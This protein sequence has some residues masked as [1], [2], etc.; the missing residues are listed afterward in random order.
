MDPEA[1]GEGGEDEFYENMFNQAYGDEEG[2]FDDEGE[3]AGDGDEDDES[4]GDEDEGPSK[5]QK[6]D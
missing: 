2:E 1:F 6:T 5:V 4:E 3:S